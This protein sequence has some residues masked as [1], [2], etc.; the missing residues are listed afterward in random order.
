MK[1][2]LNN[3]IKGFILKKDFIEKFEKFAVKNKMIKN[4][5]KI[6][7]GFSGGADST[8]L[9][10]CLAKLRSKYKFHLLAVHLNYNLR[11]KE[12]EAD[13]LFVKDFCFKRNIGIVVKNCQIPKKGN[14]ENHA[15]EIRFDYFKVIKATY[16]MDIIA[17]GHHM[18]DQAETVLFRLFRGAAISGMKGIQPISG[19]IIHPLIEFRKNEIVEFLK[20]ENISWREDLSNK[21]LLYQRNKIRWEI[22]PWIQ[23]NIN[24]QIIEK[25]CDSARIFSETDEVMRDIIH[26]KKRTLT[27]NSTLSQ[28][29]A[30][31]SEVLKLKPVLRFYFFRDLYAGVCGNEK[32]FY[33][34]H[35]SEI[36]SLLYTEGSKSIQLPH[37][38]IVLK[39]YDNLSFLNKNSIEKTT[40]DN[41]KEISS[42]R[43]RL[44]FENYR[45]YM[46]RIKK[47]PLKNQKNRNKHQIFVD[48]DKIVFPLVFRHKQ[49]GDKFIPNGMSHHKKL[50]D[51][52]IDEKVPKSQREKIILLCDAEKII[53]ICGYRIDNRVIL[54]NDSI[55]ILSLR[56]EKNCTKKVR[57]AERKKK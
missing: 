49:A 20:K 6:I 39:E 1:I 26:Y 46:K 53:W 24:P 27:K 28:K 38:V 30:S 11:G 50:K 41:S 54:N 2:F 8:A 19:D 51:F 42:I 40:L 21:N 47:I 52:F 29:I 18:E 16:K 56:I 12:S 15:R 14:M 10:Y 36:E 9:L 43:N 13:E 35:F 57:S 32:D 37:N 31:V 48:F 7:V 25:L 5:Q 17:L 23:D 3:Y 4:L 33:S 34:S 45:F 55:N 44:I 22:L